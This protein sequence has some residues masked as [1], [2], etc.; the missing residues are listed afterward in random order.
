[1]TPET[2]QLRIKVAELVG[3]TDVKLGASYDDYIGPIKVL[4]GTAP[5]S[6]L[7]CESVPELTLDWMHELETQLLIEED[8][9]LSYSSHLDNILN[10]D[11]D[12]QTMIFEYHASAIQK[13][14]ALIATME[15]TNPKQEEGR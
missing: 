10:E 2:E 8:Q 15:Q 1:M 4:F 3:W 9:Q 11:A 5:K 14:R 13:A 12:E 7:K 6:P